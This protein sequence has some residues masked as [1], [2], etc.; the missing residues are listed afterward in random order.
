MNS[1]RSISSAIRRKF[2]PIVILLVTLPTIFLA[3]SLISGLTEASSAA[4][5][6]TIAA[7]DPEPDAGSTDKV[8][9]GSRKK[10]KDKSSSGNPQISPSA[11]SGTTALFMI[12]GSGSG[13]ANGDYNSD[14]NGVDTYYRYFVE[15]PPGL[16]HL[17]IDLFDADFGA[18]GSAEATAGRDRAR[19]NFDS[20][21]TY[22]L[23]DPLGNT[24]TTQF[25]TGDTTQPAGA[26]NAWLNFFDSTGETFRDNFGTAAYNNSDGTLA[27]TTSWTETNDD[28]NVSNGQVRITGGELRVGDNGGGA[29]SIEREANLSGSGF[30]SATLTFDCR[31]TGVDAGDQLRVEVSANGGGSWTTLETFT[32]P[33]AA[34]SK[35]YNITSSIAANT[36]VR[37]LSVSGYG[38]NDFFFVDNFQIKAGNVIAGHWEVR[39]NENSSVTNGD[40]INAIGMRAHDG[41]SGSGGTELNIYADS[42]V[43]FGVNPPGSGTNTKNY[44]L[45][46]YVTSGCT[47][48]KNDF[49]Y[50][51]NSGTVGSMTFTSRGAG[52]TQTFNTSS[53]SANN[54]WRRDNLTSFTS[55][56]TSTEYGIWTAAITINS[57]LVS[58]NPNGNYVTYY[59]G[60]YQLTANP[61]TAN[62]VTNSFR[63][64]LPNDNGQAPV[65]PYLTQTYAHVS[66]FGV[67]P[68][69]SGA[70]SRYEITVSVINPTASAITFSAS[71]LVTANIPGSGAVYS[72]NTPTVSQGSVVSQ[73]A[74][75]GT[76]NITWNPGT[77]AAGATATLKYRV[78][79]TPTSTSQR[80]PMAAT[81]ASGNGTRAQWL[82]ETGNTTQTRATFLFGPI[83]ELAVTS[84]ATTAVDLIDFSATAYDKGVLLEWRTG[85]EADNLGF[86][87]YRDEGGKRSLVNSQLIAGS[88][89]TTGIHTGLK[90]GEAYAWWDHTQDKDVSYWLEDVDLNGTST[91]HGPFGLNQSEAPNPASI[92]RENLA[93]LLSQVGSQENADEATRVVES[94]ATLPPG[95]TGSGASKG[96]LAIQQVSSQA[97]IK[98]S[99]K[100]EGWYKVTQPELVR[101]GFNANVNPNSL[102][103]VVDGQELPIVVSVGKSGNF[104][105]TSA[106]EFYG[107]GLNTQATQTRT[108]WLM[109]GPG[110]GKRITQIKAEGKVGN[111]LSYS[112][113]VERKDRSVYF[114]SLR[115]GETENFFGGAITSGSANQEL[116]LPNVDLSSSAKVELEVAVQGVTL[117]PHRVSVQVNGYVAGEVILDEQKQGIERFQFP[118]SWLKEGNN[119]V[120]LTSMNSASDVSLVDYL[121]LTYQ[122]TFKADNNS[123]KLTVSARDGVTI[124]GFTDNSVRVFDV[125]EAN[126]VKELIGPVDKTSQGYAITVL[127]IGAGN[128]TLLAVTAGKAKQS[129]AIRQDLESSWR[130]S[131]QGANF[132]ILTRREF[133]SALE[134]L[135]MV[136]ESQGYKVAMVDVE[137]VYDEFSYGHKSLQAIKDFLTYANKSWKLQPKYLLLA[138]D[139]TYDPKDYL[140]I[141][142]YDLV[143]T[144]LIETAAIES[145]SD[146]WFADFNNDGISDLMVGR[147]PIRTVADAQLFV[148]K[149]FTYESKKLESSVLL[150]SDANEGFNFEQ[151]SAQLVPYLP[152]GITAQQIKRGQVDTAI[153]K[154]QLLEAFSSGQK[155]IN[156]VGH[157]SMNFWRGN[158]L[159]SEDARALTNGDHLPLVVIMNCL[160]GFYQ[161][162]TLAGLGESLVKAEKGG[163]VAVWASSAITS[164]DDQALMNQQFF[165]AV[166]QTKTIGE[167]IL[168]AKQSI[169]DDDI[170]RS[171]IF[172]GDPTM[173]LR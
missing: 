131:N 56:T 85:F 147:L 115:N 66:G 10:T 77:V 30:T 142:D 98:I 72:G 95:G 25:T 160:N 128:R 146:D 29:S 122:H 74:S 12:N 156:Y 173:G 80:I 13:T 23:I 44:S 134:P 36:R 52:F 124:D 48:T 71:N 145:A 120:Q 138:A 164:P 21:V 99:V 1:I 61:P 17:A 3:T 163:A 39:I 169:S 22:S 53:L 2:R 105:E 126:A 75:G 97:A 135:K 89:L 129:T 4:M 88:A 172:L 67:D 14:A 162:P 107:V 127:P 59:M 103:M 141:G 90:S 154:Q 165:R 140:R 161:D 32:G 150:V 139:A 157:G 5:I 55:D 60:N 73:P 6:S 168:R 116:I 41:T 45:Y 121:R 8:H 78:T 158:L 132:I 83:C 112:T 65:K 76:G 34:T 155:I 91:W 51:S 79:V 92:Y 81:P 31:T 114:S 94:S 144:K 113:T 35:S 159:T 46:P 47:C 170:R 20:S 18:G 58:G 117:L 84:R 96:S 19:T 27:W 118:H 100:S 133:F 152:A 70:P 63:I 28:N 166:F 102:Q 33:I 125:T 151:A 104:D 42:Q 130:S 171:W 167:A 26:D 15:V 137:D 153:A 136:R 7:T 111:A 110:S 148:K 57:Y 50:D 49:D 69:V 54:V 106:V 43:E 37:F 40:D 38:N 82:D 149:I 62:P 24:R 93:T 87:V 101:A 119:I 64:Y 109:V 143:P 9:D 108:Y 11:S 123:L 86:H 16:T 68:P